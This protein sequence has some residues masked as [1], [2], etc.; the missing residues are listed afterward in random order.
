MAMA[1]WSK[2]VKLG[3]GRLTV[4]NHRPYPYSCVGTC[5]FSSVSTGGIPKL[6]SSVNSRRLG[7]SVLAL[8]TEDDAL[9]SRSQVSSADPK[10]GAPLLS[11]KGSEISDS[12][13]IY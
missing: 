2:F 6:N 3:S 12:Q 8:V 10:K 9:S 1:L 7:V 4:Q 11:R 13:I 5:G